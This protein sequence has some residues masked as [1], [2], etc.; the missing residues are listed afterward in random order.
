[1]ITKFVI[2]FT[3]K[4]PAPTDDALLVFRSDDAKYVLSAF[5]GYLQADA[6]TTASWKPGDYLFQL[7]TADG[8]KES[9]EITL[10][11]NFALSDVT[12]NVKT[13]AQQMVEAIEAVIE[14][15]ATQSQKSMSVGDKSISYMDLDEL[16]KYLEYFRKKAAEEQGLSDVNDEHR[17]YFNMGF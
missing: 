4:Y 10:L 8:L 12:T 7:L 6:E 11:P 17:V 9:G 14:G 13:P 16:L 3:F 1:M 5:G 2:G 15:R